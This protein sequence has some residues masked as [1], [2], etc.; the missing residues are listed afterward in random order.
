MSRTQ[1]ADFPLYRSVSG[2]GGKTWT[3]GPSGLT[4]LCPALC[5]TAAGP[6]EGVVAVAY[7][8]RWGRHKDKGGV[9]VAFSHDHGAT[10]GEPM[11]IS[12]GAYPCMIEMEPGRVFCSYYQSSV[13]LCGSFLRIPFPTGLRARADEGG[14]RLEWDSYTGIKAKDYAYRIYR[15]A[16]PGDDMKAEDL[17]GTVKEANSYFDAGADSDKACYYR[18]AAFE[19]ETRVNVS[20][21]TAATRSPNGQ[22]P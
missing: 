4:G 18:V 20:W 16:Q 8:D 9:Y 22:R 3:T 11:W 6:P 5:R 17:V 2:D 10:W 15:S 7:H 19:G 12:G 14:I 13:R 1:Y 21:A